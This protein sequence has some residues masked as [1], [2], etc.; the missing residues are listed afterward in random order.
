MDIYFSH[1]FRDRTWKI[2]K[3]RFRKKTKILGECDDPCNTDRIMKIPVNGDT[4]EDLATCIHEA[5]HACLWDLD[6]IAIIEMSESIA[7]FLW[8][9]G[10][11]KTIK[12][13]SRYKKDVNE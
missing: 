8:K 6:E 2:V 4:A 11:R 7:D 13:K 3:S 12:I 10:W 5:G 9:L 1:K